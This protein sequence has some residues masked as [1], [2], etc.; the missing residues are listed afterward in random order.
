MAKAKSARDIAQSALYAVF[1]QGAYSNLGLNALLNKYEPPESERA[2]ASEI[3]YGVV[4]N[5]RLLDAYIASFSKTPLKKLQRRALIIL[6]MA[7]YQLIFLDRI[8]ES[9]VVNESV[10]LA[11]AHLNA[12]A[13][14]FIN[15]LLR[16]YLR[17]ENFKP[18]LPDDDIARIS[19][20]NSLPDW[21]AKHFIKSY[22]KKAGADII[23][24]AN[25]R[26][27][28]YIKRND[29]ASSHDELISALEAENAKVSA[30]DIIDGA[31]LLETRGDVTRL[32]S[33]GKGMFFFEDI[34]SQIAAKAVG[35][36]AGD[37][38][39][40]VCASPGA[41]TFA[42][43]QDMDG[44][45]QILSFDLHEKRVGLIEDAAKRLKIGIVKCGVKDAAEFDASL[46]NT[47]DAVLVDAPCSGLGTIAKK[48]DIRLKTD[49]EMKTLP[50][51]QL[52]I[53]ENSA[54]YVKSGGT[55]VYS[56]CTLN[57]SENEEVVSAFLKKHPEFRAADVPNMEKL[58]EEFYILREKT[59][60]LLPNKNFGDGFFIAKMIKE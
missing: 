11:R 53:L 14:G 58:N 47:A 21:M 36:K 4:Q 59:V 45:G 10:K 42:M 55:V 19:V 35:A 27:N 9:A 40:D 56:T 2:L 57:P 24:C 51:I 12:G 16:S 1:Y 17:A 28:V 54:R 30:V 48:P 8:P 37:I 41:K 39:I 46:E 34:T 23:R 15:G 44:Q 13:A 18:K 60:T 31:Y 7:F 29:Y 33:F 6:R 52:S 50:E 32:E 38:V 3:V 43:A 25:I 22:G 49:E 26:P 5:Y 20:E